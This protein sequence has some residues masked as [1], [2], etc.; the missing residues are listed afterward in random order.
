MPCLL[1]TP[2]E[3]GGSLLNPGL[4]Q[5]LIL[6]CVNKALLKG[7]P[8]GEKPKEV[9]SSLKKLAGS[10]WAESRASSGHEAWRRDT[11]LFYPAHH[12][13][14]CRVHTEGLFSPSPTRLLGW[15]TGYMVTQCGLLG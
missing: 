4:L 15:L 10:L 1:T 6:E 12:T 2:R 11:I 5:L 7:I 9:L 13:L 14:P 3:Q 8:E